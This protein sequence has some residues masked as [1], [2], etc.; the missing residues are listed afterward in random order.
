MIIKNYLDKSIWPS[1]LLLPLANMGLLFFLSSNTASS[2]NID[3]FTI[4]KQ[5]VLLIFVA[6]AE[7]LF[8][9]G[10]LLHELLFSFQVKPILAGTIV[11]ALFGALHLMNVFSYA[12]LT[13]AIVQGLCAFAV[14]FDLTAIYCKF[15]SVVPCIFV[16]ILINITSIGLDDGA[17]KLAL[18]SVEICL[19]L[20]VAVLYF[21]HAYRMFNDRCFFNK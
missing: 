1:L 17:E 3:V 14:G 4:V 11:S 15:K 9:R 6:V 19:L 16:H 20:F 7:E 5:L 12:S 2:A 18:T 21:V 13:Y 8:F 10:L